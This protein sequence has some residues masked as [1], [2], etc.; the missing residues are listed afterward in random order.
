MLAV[1]CGGS[2]SA[3]DVP[4]GNVAVVNG[5]PRGIFVVVLMNGEMSDHAHD[6]IGRIFRSFP[7][8]SACLRA[9]PS[10]EFATSPAVS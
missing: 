5:R 1:A 8:K 6:G 10:R 2:S 9:A 3:S 4:K 7:K